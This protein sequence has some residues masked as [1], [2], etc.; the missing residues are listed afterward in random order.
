LIRGGFHAVF[1]D[2]DW[3]VARRASALTTDLSN[4]ESA[5]GKGVVKR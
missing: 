1:V 4:D 2:A 5:R 3:D